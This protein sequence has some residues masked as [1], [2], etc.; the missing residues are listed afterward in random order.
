MFA[1]SQPALLEDEGFVLAKDLL[2]EDSLR[3]FYFTRKLGRWEGIAKKARKSLRRFG[4]GLEP[5]CILDVACRASKGPTDIFFLERSKPRVFFNGILA[6]KQAALAGFLANDI[7]LNSQFGPEEVL[8]SFSSYQGLL[9]ALDAGEDPWS[10]LLSFF[11]VFF[12]LI[13]IAPQL[14]RCVRCG[15]LLADHPRAGLSVSEAGAV[16]PAC[17]AKQERM[18]GS[19]LP[20]Y[21]KGAQRS[22]VRFY[23]EHWQY[24]FDRA[25]LSYRVYR[26][27]SNP[28][29]PNPSEEGSFP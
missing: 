1:L 21:A 7:V 16:C 6:S 2:G 27:V 24:R 17:L 5:F 26:E 22:L 13:G 11:E 15:L 9:V 10:A 28:S 14:K 19:S 8:P 4:G 23:L 20:L 18:S 29:M 12:R 25:L 3:V